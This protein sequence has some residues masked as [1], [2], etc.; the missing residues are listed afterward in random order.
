MADGYFADVEGIRKGS[1]HV[2]NA[3]QYSEEALPRFESGCAE[4]AG[5]WGEE[6]GDDEFANAVGP[7]VR[8]EQ[9]QVRTT[10][11]DITGAFLALVD[12]LAA[13]REHV[14]R[15]S[16]QASDAIDAHGAESG[17]RH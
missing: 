12:A 11:M 10:V 6:G 16:F 4:Y 3:V 5:W 13:Q 15:P 1:K 2:D 17:N 9:E 7:Q 14:Q 8:R